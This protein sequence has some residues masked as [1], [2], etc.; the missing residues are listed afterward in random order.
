MLSKKKR[1][2][3]EVFQIL[4]KEGKILST[5]LFL[6]YFNK[7]T[8]PQFA[9]VAPKKIFKSA[10]LRNKYKRI[11]YNT[12]RG[13]ILKQGRGIFVYKKQSQITPTGEIKENILFILKKVGFL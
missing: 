7:N 3:K 1:V 5:P 4:M 13:V 11:G 12:L 6:F 8:A 9:F 2:T 10:V